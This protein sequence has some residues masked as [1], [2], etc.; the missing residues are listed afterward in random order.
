MRDAYA[1][2]Y[3]AQANAYSD[4]YSVGDSHDYFNPYGYGNS[5]Y[6]AHSHSHGHFTTEPDAYSNGLARRLL[7]GRNKRWHAGLR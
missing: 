2:F 4:R 1:Y 5:D 6:N 3:A 7:F